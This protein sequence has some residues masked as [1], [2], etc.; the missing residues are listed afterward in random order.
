MLGP[1]VATDARLVDVLVEISLGLAGTRILLGNPVLPGRSGLDES[2]GCKGLSRDTLG[3][4]IVEPEASCCSIVGATGHRSNR[5]SAARPACRLFEMTED[6]LP[7]H[8][9][10]L[11]AGSEASKMHLRS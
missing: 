3:V 11:T 7:V 5:W 10:C 6:A 4:T 1:R 8:L 9:R 2:L